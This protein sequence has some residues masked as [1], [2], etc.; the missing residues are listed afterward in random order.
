[1]T[2]VQQEGSTGDLEGAGAVGLTSGGNK[3]LASKVGCQHHAHIALA[4]GLWVE[5]KGLR[6][7]V[8][9]QNAGKGQVGCCRCKELMGKKTHKLHDW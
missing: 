2:H 3:D 4:L 8:E 6:E 7:L 5:T 1:M 9:S